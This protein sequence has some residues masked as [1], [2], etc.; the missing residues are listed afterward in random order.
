MGPV[1]KSNKKRKNLL[2]SRPLLPGYQHVD[3]KYYY[4]LANE[5]HTD[6]FARAARTGA[7]GP[8]DDYPDRIAR[9]IYDNKMDY[10]DPVTRDRLSRK[11]AFEKVYTKPTLEPV[12]LD[13]ES[14]FIKATTRTLKTNRRRMK[15][16]PILALLA[17]QGLPM[18]LSQVRSNS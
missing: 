3:G 12:P 7:L 4:G 10:Y 2:F 13:S 8:W 9:D 6:I 16:L 1:K 17:A 18:L 11:Q 5:I 14:P 15:G